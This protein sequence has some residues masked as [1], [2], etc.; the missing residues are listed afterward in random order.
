MRKREPQ[1]TELTKIKQ[2]ND[3]YKSS[4]TRKPNIS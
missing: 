3:F 1:F 4:K 2:K